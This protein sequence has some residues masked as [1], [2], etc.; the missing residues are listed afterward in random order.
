MNLKNRKIV[1]LLNRHYITDGVYIYNFVNSL[2]GTHN[3]EFDS[4]LDNQGK[5][6][7]Q[8]GTKEY[9]KNTD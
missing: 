3:E 4:F 7:V 6:F 2:I 8:L 5:E 1:S 9:I